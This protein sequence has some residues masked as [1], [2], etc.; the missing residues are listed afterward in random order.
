MALKADEEDP[1]PQSTA[2]AARFRKVG[3]A[4]EDS[5]PN[6]APEWWRLEVHLG[7]LVVFGV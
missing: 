3:E 4:V 5:T 1:K 6:G 7:P 2:W